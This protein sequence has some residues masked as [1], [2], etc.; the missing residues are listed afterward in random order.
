MQQAC[1][2][3]EVRVSLKW[4]PELSHV[5]T[6]LFSRGAVAEAI[7]FLDEVV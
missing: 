7:A 2:D 3:H 1:A 4:L 5:Q 6:F